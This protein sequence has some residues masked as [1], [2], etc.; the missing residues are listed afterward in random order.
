VAGSENDASNNSRGAE[1]S[2]RVAVWD[3]TGTNESS[4][5]VQHSKLIP[6]DIVTDLDGAFMVLVN[7]PSEEVVADGGRVG[8]TYGVGVDGQGRM[9]D[10]C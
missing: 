3:P 2:Y 8:A 4:I 6:G 5:S 9:R 7:D 10:L 1:S